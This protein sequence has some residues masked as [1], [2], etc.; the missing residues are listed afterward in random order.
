[1]QAPLNMYTLPSKA[2]R[3]ILGW[4]TSKLEAFVKKRRH[5]SDSHRKLRAGRE[6]KMPAG[7]DVRWLLCSR[8][9]DFRGC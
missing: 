5:Q 6:P 2:R 8:L 4:Q 3:N 7:S 9:W 1:M